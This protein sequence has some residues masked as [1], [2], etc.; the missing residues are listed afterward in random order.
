MQYKPEYDDLLFET[1]KQR[2]HEVLYYPES[3]LR[4]NYRYLVSVD[5][6]AFVGYEPVK[7]WQGTSESVLTTGNLCITTTIGLVLSVEAWWSTSCTAIC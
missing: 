6:F 5:T 2:L 1:A 4:F 3:I 7:W